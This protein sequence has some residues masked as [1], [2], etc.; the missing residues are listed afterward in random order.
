MVDIRSGKDCPSHIVA[1]GHVDELQGI[2]FDN[3]RV[4]VGSR[5]TITELLRSSFLAT[6][7]LSLIEAAQ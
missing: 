2:G 4:C 5:T 1:L 3:G 7:S 6:Q